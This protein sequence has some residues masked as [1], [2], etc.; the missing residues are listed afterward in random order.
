MPLHPLVGTLE[1]V[2]A[3]TTTLV[4]GTKK[5]AGGSKIWLRLDSVLGRSELVEFNKSAILRRVSIS[6][7]DLQILGL[8]SVV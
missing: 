6:A 2:S 1:S 8:L 4:E 3:T 7:R 5:K